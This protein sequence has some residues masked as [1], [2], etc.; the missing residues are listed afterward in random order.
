M[1][2]MKDIHDYAMQLLAYRETKKELEASLDDV[3]KNIKEI[4]EHTLNDLMEN[5]GLAGVS[6]EDLDVSRSVI[7]RGGYTKHHDKN[8]FKFLFDTNNEGALKQCVIIDLIS[9]PEIETLLNE[10]NIPY[11]TEY[12][13]HHATLSSILKELIATGQFTTEDIDKYSV[14]AQ[15]QIKV[16]QKQ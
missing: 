4:E 7:F 5:Q 13:I 10:H 11:T 1:S 15:P 14:Y 12:S 9:C 6:L 2:D 16:K 8:A 3:K